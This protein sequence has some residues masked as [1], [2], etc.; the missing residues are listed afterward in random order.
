MGQPKQRAAFLSLWTTPTDSSHDEDGSAESPRRDRRRTATRWERPAIPRPVQGEAFPIMGLQPQSV[1]RRAPEGG[2]I[3]RA[4]SAAESHGGSEN[5]S[6]CAESCL[7][8]NR[9]PPP[10]NSRSASGWR[11][12]AP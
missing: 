7:G 6:C 8:D 3:S 1:A 12:S 4:G 2:A 10:A 5:K 9:S 11:P